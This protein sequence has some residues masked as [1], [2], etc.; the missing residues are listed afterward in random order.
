MLI[1]PIVVEIIQS[2][3]ANTL[4]LLTWGNNDCMI[5]DVLFKQVTV[6]HK[7]MENAMTMQDSNDPK[8]RGRNI[9]ISQ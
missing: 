4:T 6:L 9:K 5:V 7:L 3:P 8:K 1:Y 2:G